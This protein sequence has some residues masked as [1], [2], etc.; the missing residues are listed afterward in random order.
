MANAANDSLLRLPLD[1][2]AVILPRLPLRD[3]AQLAATAH[4]VR[5]RVLAADPALSAVAALVAALRR[6]FRAEPPLE[7]D[8]RDT[9]RHRLIDA[10]MAGLR[11]AAQPVTPDRP[12]SWRC[13]YLHH[14]P[15]YPK[16][17]SC[18]VFV[19]LL[20]EVAAAHDAPAAPFAPPGHA[21]KVQLMCHHSWEPRP[22]SDQNK[23]YSIRYGT[24]AIRLPDGR[25]YRIYQYTVSRVGTDFFE[26]AQLH[27]GLATVG[28]ELGVSEESMVSTIRAAFPMDSCNSTNDRNTMY[29]AVNAATPTGQQQTPF[30]IRDPEFRGRNFFLGK[31]NPGK[32]WTLEECQLPKNSN[33]AWDQ[34]DGIQLVPPDIRRVLAASVA[35][36]SMSPADCSRLHRWAARMFF[37]PIYGR[38]WRRGDRSFW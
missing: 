15:T 23:D 20:L 1:V 7:A 35:W 4:N 3:R 33:F 27:S 34:L 14:P 10:V 30:F 17:Y 11:A 9:P 2:F 38:E 12:K 22:Y 5:A 21:L 29:V 25:E 13:T 31:L 28:R 6:L 37:E 26:Q 24:F 8:W 18:S 32:V 36:T 16:S 19:D